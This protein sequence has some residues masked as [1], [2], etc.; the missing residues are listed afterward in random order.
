VHRRRHLQWTKAGW[1]RG[2]RYRRLPDRLEQDMGGARSGR[3]RR[4]SRARSAITAEKPLVF[5]HIRDERAPRLSRSRNHRAT[6][7][8]DRITGGRFSSPFD[9]ASPVVGVVD[10]RQSRSPASRPMIPGADRPSP[11]RWVELAPTFAESKPR[12][13]AAVSTAS[14][15]SPTT[16]ASTTVSAQRIP[17]CRHPLTAPRPVHR[18]AFHASSFRQHARHNLER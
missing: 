4:K 18:C 15:S 10:A 11:T 17:A 6:A 3:P 9:A 14:C 8:H 2:S 16:R 7:N 13:A 5:S 1:W 12:T